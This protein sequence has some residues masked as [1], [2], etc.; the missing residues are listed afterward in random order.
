MVLVF[1]ISL[2]ACGGEPEQNPEIV[3]ENKEPVY[4]EGHGIKMEIPSVWQDTFTAYYKEVGEGATAFELREFMTVING[5]EARIVTI[6]SFNDESWKT[7]IALTP[8]GEKMKIGTSKDGT[9]HFTI[10]F[11]ET[12][13]KNE[14]DQ[15]KF[16]Q[17]VAA[18]KECCEKIEITE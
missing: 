2:V 1:A 12:K 9:K 13:F 8:E 18:A 17:I 16:D 7:A 4:Y 3:N 11:E 15:E 6:A 10:R 5:D 14:E